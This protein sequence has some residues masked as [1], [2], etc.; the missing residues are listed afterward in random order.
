[1][2]KKKKSVDFTDKEIY[3]E[4]DQERYRLIRFYPANM[5][6]DVTRYV[7]GKKDGQTNLPFAHLPKTI[8]QLIKPKR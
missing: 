5:T 7:E 3:F 8:K 1:M 2:A 6:V 4:L